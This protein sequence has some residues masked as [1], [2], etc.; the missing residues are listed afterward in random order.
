MKIKT[1]ISIEES[2]LEKAKKV[3]IREDRSTSYVLE[4][5]IEGV[6]STA[7]ETEHFADAIK[8]FADHLKNR[9][10]EIIKSSQREDS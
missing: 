3:A 4:K 2:V 8:K 5:I 7:D 6:L 1:S 10:K 9:S